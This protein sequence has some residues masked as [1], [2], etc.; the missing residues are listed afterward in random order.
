MVALHEVVWECCVGANRLQVCLDIILE[1]MPILL[2]R[3][4]GN[5]D[6]L[7]AVCSL[8]GSVIVW[9]HPIMGRPTTW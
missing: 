8:K 2:W 9:P 3:E 6:D 1:E 5:E 4:D 7:F